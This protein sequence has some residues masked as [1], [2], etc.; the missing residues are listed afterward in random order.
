[1][2]TADP[3][4][5]EGVT[6]RLR[7]DYPGTTWFPEGSWFEQS[8]DEPYPDPLFRLASGF[9]RVRNP[10]SILCSV[11]NGFLYGSKSAFLGSKMSVGAVRWTHGALLR[12]ETTGF[13]M[14]DFPDWTAPT[15]V[16]FD[17]ALD[18]LAD[19]LSPG[20]D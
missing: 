13:L 14:T 20:K 3:L 5:L 4:R 7:V 11:S 15:A 8:W 1:M 6:A 18:W 10:A 2:E 17:G 16:R 9:E 12:S 19:H